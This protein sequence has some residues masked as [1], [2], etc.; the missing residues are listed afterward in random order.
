MA[1]KLSLIISVHAGN[2]CPAFYYN[3]VLG[4]HAFEKDA[5][6]SIEVDATPECNDE[7]RAP[8]VE[9]NH[10]DSMAT[11]D[12]INEDD[13]FIIELMAMHPNDDDIVV[14][15]IEDVDVE[16]ADGEE[17]TDYG[18]RLRLLLCGLVLIYR[19]QNIEVSMRILLY[20]HCNF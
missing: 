17:A 3:I 5:D 20:C 10:L 4:L 12:D 11:L 9:P 7:T 15:D 1:S 16:G 8:I 14:D 19:F 6:D 18:V 2:G 13:A